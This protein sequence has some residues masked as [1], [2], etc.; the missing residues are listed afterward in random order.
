MS[1]FEPNATPRSSN[2]AVARRLVRES[3]GIQ[4]GECVTILGRADSL[5]FCEAIELE[6]RR[7]GAFPLVIVGSDA[8]LLAALAD[9]ALS[10][11]ALAA[12]SPPLLAALTASQVVITTFFERGNPADF[13]SC[14]PAR[15]RALRASEE[16]SSNIIFDGTRRWI[17]TEVP[18]PGQAQALGVDWTVLHD[19]FWRA[20]SVDYRP[21][22]VQAQALAR[23]LAQ[24]G[25]LHLSDAQGR[26]DLWLRRGTGGRPLER[27]D[28]VIGPDDLAEGAL[29][30]NL[31][32]GEV[33]FAP[34]ED[35]AW[36]R[37]YIEVAYWQGQA[38]RSLSLEFEG[39]VVRAVAAEV[40]LELFREVV[41]EAGG[42]SARLGEFGIGLNPAVDRVTG[43]TLLDEKMI[44]TCHL[45]LGENRALGGQNNSALHWDLVVQRA[46][47]RADGEILLKDGQLMI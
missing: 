29:Y 18:T 16:A 10:E 4:A 21:I 42:D 31:P 46:I 3:A 36:G 22:G 43:L 20:M 12:A 9:P 32:S 26:T 34:P 33:C 19:L 45:A 2:S 40:G 35:S 13:S 6:C 25:Q 17:G 11:T 38:V 14:D 27:D 47:L 8:A 37:A 1:E 23:R 44:G 41:A 15:L 7:L 28:G 30:L 5:D 39:G 24:A